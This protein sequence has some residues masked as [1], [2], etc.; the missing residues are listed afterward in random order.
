MSLLLAGALVDDVTKQVFD[1]FAVGGV[2]PGKLS[3]CQFLFHARRAFAEARVEQLAVSTF[4]PLCRAWRR[5]AQK[6]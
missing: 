4:S 1:L 5:W 2:G 6:W 3:G